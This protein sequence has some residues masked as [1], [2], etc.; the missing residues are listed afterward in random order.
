MAGLTA[1][2]T[3]RRLIDMLQNKN[4]A[5]KLLRKLLGRQ[6]HIDIPH[7][8]DALSY[9]DDY[10]ADITVSHTT[11]SGTVIGLPNPYVVPAN[12]KSAAFTFE[13][14]YYWDSYFTAL[15]LVGSHQDLAEGMLENLLHI[16]KRFQFIPNASRMYF[17]SRSQPPILTS[18]I[19]LIYETGN[20]TPAWLKER[21]NIA[22]AEY[23]N[24]WMAKKHP[25]WHQVHH[26]L[27]RYYDINVLHD[28]AEA[29]SGWDMTP[30]FERKCLDFL[31]IDLNCLLYKYE[32]D[33]AWA[34]ELFGNAKEAEHWKDVA[35]KRRH[36]IND[37][38]WHDRRGF[39]FDY[40]Y[41]KKQLGDTW[42]LAG[43]YAL[44]S[45][46]ATREQASKM[47]NNLIKFEH[48]GGLT[49]TTQPLIDITMFGSLK[50]QWAYP[51]GWAPLHL[52]VVEGLEK[53]GFHGEA[54]RIARRWIHTNLAWFEQ[55]GVFL[56]KYNVVKIHK[57]P[58][59][60]VY[61]SQTGFGWTNA[62]FVALCKQYLE[63]R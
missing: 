24:V 35:R 40:N 7:I 46:V 34:A 13:E 51:N 60:G 21:M 8:D 3:G 56:E 31:P 30:R 23:R 54:E 14:Q 39:Y 12:D 1:V 4:I 49:T 27:S 17:M 42:S 6:G 59:E 19:R 58:V 32:K 28:L 15:G 9:I 33:F 5:K 36:A 37:L 53:Y 18:Y 41:Q 11:D 2:Y 16:F 47:V 45:G 61:P 38:M 20:K 29:E 63:N 44:W 52:I 55:H 50:S 62:V 25:F 43:F 57:P 10:W 26:G 22:E 48:R